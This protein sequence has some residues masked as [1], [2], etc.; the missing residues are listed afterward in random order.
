LKSRLLL[1]VGQRVPPL[2]ERPG[3]LVSWQPNG[4][5]LCEMSYAVRTPTNRGQF[6]LVLQPTADPDGVAP[7]APAGTWTVT[8]RNLSLNAGQIVHAWIERDETLYGHPRRGRPSRFDDP[9]YQRYDDNGQIIEIDNASQ[10][11]RDGTINAIATGLTTIVAGGY[12]GNRTTAVRYSSAGPITPALGAAAPHRVG[13]DVLTISEDA[14]NH[15][16]V[17]AAGSRSGSTVAM[18]GTSV[19]S[20]Q[21]ARICAERGAVGNQADRN[22]IMALAQN[23]ELIYPFPEPRPRPQRGHGRMRPNPVRPLAR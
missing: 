13:P 4:P 22:A 20:A 18:G 6:L 11:K 7:I 17:L 2:G 23:D 12:I 1:R 5:V 14:L 16:G 21:L 8:I 3:F 19:A 9:Q 15:G 10:L